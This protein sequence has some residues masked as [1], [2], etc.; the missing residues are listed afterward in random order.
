M[1]AYMAR[2]YGGPDTLS[3][4]DVAIPEPDEGAVLVRVHASSV[5]ALDW[6]ML[7]GK[8]H[9]VR[10]TDGLRAPKE[11]RIGVDAA[12]VVEAVGRGV[13]DLRVGDRVFGARTGA[14]AEYVAGRNFVPLPDHLTFEEGAAIPVAGSTALQALRDKAAVRA[15]QRVLVTGAGGGVG[16]FAVQIARALGATVTASTSP[17]KAAMVRS[18]GAEVVLDRTAVDVTRP[19][20]PY[21]VIIDVGSDRR[22]GDMRHALRPD[23]TL[24]IVGAGPGDWIGPLVRVGAGALRSRFGKQRF[25]PFLSQ[26]RRDDIFALQDLL[27]AGTLRPVI[28][29]TYPFADLPA[30]IRHVESGTVAGK[31]VITVA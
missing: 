14:F 13:T 24:V 11:P 22:L 26:I 25:L 30:A 27:V 4:E 12:G 31:V 9:V 5:N 8:P 28:D 17:S 23:G 20:D 18:I 16:T 6:H 29:R 3:I 21:D 7:R 2:R 10:V 1:H 19:A 15:G